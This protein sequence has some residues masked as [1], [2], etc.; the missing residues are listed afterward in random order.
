MK[1]SKCRVFYGLSD[2][3]PIVAVVGLGAN[4][5]GYNDAEGIDEDRE[6]IRLAIATGARTLR[7]IG[8]VDEID[9]D[10]C[11]DGVAAAEG[12]NL[13]LYS[14]DELK[15]SSLKKTKIK[16]NP[17]NSDAIPKWNYGQTLA[18]GQNFTRK[19][20]ETP[21]NIMTPTRFANIA[22]ESLTHL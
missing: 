12:S 11:G 2:E 10:D 16:L 21:A 6:N 22:V 20:M 15:G 17:L 5:A 9:V 4:N 1:K 7:E 19:L 3:H 13:S 14:Y 8:S 18:D